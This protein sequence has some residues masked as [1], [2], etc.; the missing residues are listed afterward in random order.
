MDLSDLPQLIV[1]VYKQLELDL[2]DLPQ[3]I[4]DVYKQ[5]EL[6]LSDLSQLIV[7]VYKQLKLDLSDLF[8]LISNVWDHSEDL[9]MSELIA[10]VY[11]QLGLDLSDL[12]QLIADVYKQLDLD[13]SELI[14]DVYRQLEDS[15]NSN[16][17]L[18]KIIAKI[19]E[20]L[21]NE[22]NQDLADLLVDIYKKLEDLK[23]PSYLTIGVYEFL[24]DKP[25]FSAL[26][27]TISS[28]LQVNCVQTMVKFK[29]LEVIKSFSHPMAKQIVLYGPPGTGKTKLAQE[30]AKLII[31]DRIIES[32][33]SE[34]LDPVF[35]KLIEDGT[36]YSINSRV[37]RE[38]ESLLKLY[39]EDNKNIGEIE[40]VKREFEKYIYDILCERN[41]EI[42]QLHPS[43]SYE[44]FIRSIHIS[45]SNNMPHYE[46]KDKVFAELCKIAETNREQNFVLII[47]EINRANLPLILGEL[48]YALEYR[49]KE[50][51][52]PY[53]KI[54]VPENL[55]I[56][57]TMNTADRS[58]VDIDYAIR[59][60]FTF[61]QVK[62]DGNCIKDP[63]LRKFYNDVIDKIFDP[64]NSYLSYDFKD[65]YDDVKVGHT[66][67][68]GSLETVAFKFV[69][70]VIP[71]LIEYIKDGVLT[72][73]TL[74]FLKEYFEKDI[75]SIDMEDVKN[76]VNSLDI[77]D[78]S[79]K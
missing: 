6:N 4:V 55:Y 72:T 63:K 25:N 53:G 9:S 60:R 2:S 18:F 32:L 16:F 70:Q 11:R 24:N 22:L 30:I 33:F 28:K 42:V 27:T 73:A 8:Q 57:A 3:L 29:I 64:E 44:D 67:F 78:E 17:D 51:E 10:N 54:K 50:V 31:L 37:I 36:I 23:D 76:K 39:T 19:Y 13:L 40:K 21:K 35:K 7:D 69:Y 20:I 45:I 47:D 52:T 71:L 58:V 38:N 14:T 59:R 5:L 61:F 49:N 1:D 62:A 46:V 74:D 65:L 15:R 77:S 12:S 41:I 75:K 26:L 48:I 68:L 79:Q 43:Y 34:T 56:I 66:Y